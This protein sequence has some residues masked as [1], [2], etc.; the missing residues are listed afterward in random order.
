MNNKKTVIITGANRGIGFSIAKKFAKNNFNLILCTRADFKNE[1]LKFE[2][3][4]KI[5]CK[6]YVFNFENFES[7][8][9]NAKKILIE[10]EQID[11]LINNA[12]YI[13]TGLFQMTKHE[14]FRKIFEINFFSQIFFTQVI[15]GKLKKSKS[16]SIINI[17][18]T[19][20]LDYDMGRMAYVCSKASIIAFTKTLSKENSMFKIR[21]N[22]I[23]PGLI[24]TEM[25]K[26]NT[27]EKVLE[28]LIKKNSSKKIGSTSEIADVAFYLISEESKYINGEVIRVDGGMS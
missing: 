6:N 21:V 16:P 13:S 28:D 8:I 20:G 9:E 7:A 23:A 14:E 10:N 2:E 27:S 17:S 25:L 22:S 11:A 19:S 12:G 26:K 24:D 15:I 5:S 18:S 3:E 4:Y 1:C